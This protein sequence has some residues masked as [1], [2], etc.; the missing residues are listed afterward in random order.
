MNANRQEK[1]QKSLLFFI[2][3]WE[4]IHGMMNGMMYLCTTSITSGFIASTPTLKH[5]SPTQQEQPKASYSDLMLGPIKLSA[6]KIVKM[7]AS[8]CSHIK[9]NRNIATMITSGNIEKI[10][11]EFT[12][13]NLARKANCVREVLIDDP[14]YLYLDGFYKVFGWTPYTKEELNHLLLLLKK[15]FNSVVLIRKQ[16]HNKDMVVQ[17]QG[18]YTIL[19][20]IEGGQHDHKLMAEWVRNKIAFLEDEGDLT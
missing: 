15:H 11:K 13:F 10:K 7:K 2:T 17:I 14:E 18:E 9:E 19:E 4:K 12:S 20:V 1:R 5:R 6:P 3:R 8:G 16:P